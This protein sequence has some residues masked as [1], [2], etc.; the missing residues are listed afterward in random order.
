LISDWT[1]AALLPPDLTRMPIARTDMIMPL[2]FVAGQEIIRQGEPGSRFY[3]ISRGRGEGGRRSGSDEKV[4]ATLGPGQYFGE[5]ALLESSGRNATVRAVEDTTVLS[6][7][8]KDFTALVESL[9]ILGQ[10]FSQ[11]R[12]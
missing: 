4:L 11:A 3:M 7:A 6:I 1:S 5:V 9:P 8:R 12:G 2:R 10:A